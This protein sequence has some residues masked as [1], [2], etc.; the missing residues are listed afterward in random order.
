M[1][2]GRCVHG[3]PGEVDWTTIEVFDRVEFLQRWES[4]SCT[5]QQVPELWRTV[6]KRELAQ[7]REGAGDGR[8]VPPFSSNICERVQIA[9]KGAY[10]TADGISIG[11]SEMSEER[12]MVIVRAYDLQHGHGWVA[13]HG[14][15][16]WRK[17]GKE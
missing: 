6:D 8:D 17:K 3:P 1:G 15:S 5:V 11:L 7:T 14:F 2:E 13:I 16:L 10:K 9:R 12:E 4:G